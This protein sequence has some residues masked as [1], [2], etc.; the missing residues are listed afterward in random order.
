M[1]PAAK[2]LL[3]RDSRSFWMVQALKPYEKLEAEE[4]NQQ[5]PYT[6]SARF[7][8]FN[9]VGMPLLCHPGTSS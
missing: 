2:L 5:Q 9:D 6:T 1:V 3:R 8:F 4:K 7:I